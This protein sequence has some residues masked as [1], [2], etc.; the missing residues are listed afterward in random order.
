ML[1]YFLLAVMFTNFVSAQNRVNKLEYYFEDGY[2]YMLYNELV[3]FAGNTSVSYLESL[4]N[5]DGSMSKSEFMDLLSDENRSEEFNQ[6]I[7]KNEEF[8]I[9]SDYNLKKKSC[10][11]SFF[12]LQDLKTDITY[13]FMKVKGAPDYKKQNYLVRD[14]IQSEDWILHDEFKMIEGQKCQKVTTTFR[15]KGYTG[16]VNTSIPVFKG[17]YVF[18]NTPGL[19][20]QL[21]Q[22]D[23][24]LQWSLKSFKTVEDNSFTEEMN[25]IQMQL[26]QCSA[27][28]REDLR[29]FFIKYEK[30]IEKK[31]HGKDC[32]NCDSKVIVINIECFDDME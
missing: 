13:R 11:G 19:I 26:N 15:C 31:N 24:D 4:H 10:N 5:T 6:H 7:D 29:D 27:L 1:R 14:S 8:K 18:K 17:P 16:W 25:T 9:Y 28:S 3:T 20:V 2:T 22:D 21:Y 32:L 12:I 30:E 23:R